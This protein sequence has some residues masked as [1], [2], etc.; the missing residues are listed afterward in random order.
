MVEKLMV[1][2]KVSSVGCLPFNHHFVVTTST[3]GKLK[4][5]LQEKTTR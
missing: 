5:T 1:K 4:F 2:Q 3:K